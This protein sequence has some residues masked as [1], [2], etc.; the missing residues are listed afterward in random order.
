MY[1]AINSDTASIPRPEPIMRVLVFLLCI[2]EAIVSM[3]TYTN[4][5]KEIDLMRCSIEFPGIMNEVVANGMYKTD[6]R[7]L[8]DLPAKSK[9]FK[10]CENAIKK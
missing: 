4:R 9:D 7:C 6:R 5:I 10:L 3:D 1:H 8:P 2:Y